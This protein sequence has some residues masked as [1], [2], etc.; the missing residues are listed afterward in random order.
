MSIRMAIIKKGEIRN[1]GE[2]VENVNWCSYY[3]NSI[4]IPQKMKNSTI[5]YNPVFPL[6]AIYSK[7]AKTLIQKD[8]CTAIVLAAFFFFY[9]S[10]DMETTQVPTDR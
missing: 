9:S 3:G 6:L 7:N 4:E 1:V 2:N 5:I 8:I 10:Q